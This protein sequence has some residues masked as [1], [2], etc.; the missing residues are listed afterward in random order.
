MSAIADQIP[1]LHQRPLE[2]G[3][4]RS[5]SYVDASKEASALGILAYGIE[6]DGLTLDGALGYL[7][8]PIHGRPGVSVYWP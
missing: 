2:Y 7:R 5:V 3:E 8:E 1:E 6:M 4:V